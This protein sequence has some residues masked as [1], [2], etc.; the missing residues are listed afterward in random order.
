MNHNSEEEPTEDELRKQIDRGDYHDP[1][2]LHSA[3]LA[4]KQFEKERDFLERCRKA[5]LSAALDARKSSRV[6]IYVSL[7][8]LA[9]AVMA[10]RQEVV[11]LL[12]ALF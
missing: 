9:I 5:S 3:R 7:I 8:S 1:T 2:E 10:A 4:L 6:A 11:A 12:R